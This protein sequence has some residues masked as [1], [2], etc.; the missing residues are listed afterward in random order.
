ME[1]TW[2]WLPIL[3]L[4]SS[5]IWDKLINLTRFGSVEV[6]WNYLVIIEHSSIQGTNLGARNSAMNDTDKIHDVMG[7]KILLSRERKQ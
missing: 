4:P 7:L 2:V 5:V 1:E 3:P 6:T